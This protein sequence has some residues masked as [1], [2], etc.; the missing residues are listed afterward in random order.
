MLY[1]DPTQRQPTPYTPYQQGPA[2]DKVPGVPGPYPFPR[3]PMPPQRP[4]QSG[5][6]RGA[7]LALLLLLALILGVGLFAGWTFARSSSG[8]TGSS[9][10]GTPAASSQSP[11]NSSAATSNLE[12]LREAAIAK[13]EPSV[14][15]IQGTTSQG[16]SVGSGVIID[17]NGDI[18]T[19]NHVVDGVNSLEVV[20]S[21]GVREQAQVVGTSPSNDLAIVHIQPFAGMV[22]ATLGDS[23]QLVVGQDVL[24]IGN[25]LTYQGTVTDGVVSALNRSAQESRAVNLTGLIQ[26]S[27]AINPGNSG[28]ALIDLNGQVVGITT[29]SAIDT[30]T[31]TPAN[32]IGFAIPS[33]QVQAVIK[34]VLGS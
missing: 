31:N 19:N 17:K 10:L 2:T 5:V 11:S 14:V 7:I 8:A 4:R 12:A 22:V 25:P 32:G 21:N 3:Q 13:A 29:L 28:G 6:R 23:S 33:N 20:L 34:Q 9:L 26:T 30:E 1:N 16:E 15:E 24:A 18:V 27:A